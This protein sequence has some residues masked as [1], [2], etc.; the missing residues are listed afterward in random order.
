MRNAYQRIENAH[1][2]ALHETF[3]DD[4]PMNI[5]WS[6]GDE[7]I[8]TKVYG[9]GLFTTMLDEDDNIVHEFDEFPQPVKV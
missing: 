8:T 3:T 5:G 9:I 6:T 2:K 1:I 4:E 7:I